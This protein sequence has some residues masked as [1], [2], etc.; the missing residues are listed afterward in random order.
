MA[1]PINIKCTRTGY[2]AKVSPENYLAVGPVKPSEAFSV[3]LDVDSTAYEIVS[4]K[5]NEYFIITD[6]ILVGNK[7]IN[8]TVDA[9]VTIYEANAAD[10]TTNLK[11][12]LSVPVP[13]SDN[14]IITG[15]HLKTSTAISV[16][17]TTSDDDVL[18]NI[19]G[20]YID[21]T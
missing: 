12:L 1:L 20:Y 11:T 17:G 2:E 13:R 14:I 16:V 21:A 8:T 15:I 18:V 19:L 9:V 4:A 10:L 3:T 5:S 7:N 6:I